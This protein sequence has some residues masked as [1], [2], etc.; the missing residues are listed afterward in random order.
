M[1][2]EQLNKKITRARYLCLIG[3]SLLTFSTIIASVFLAD[4]ILFGNFTNLGVRLY[5]L[6]IAIGLLLTLGSFIYLWGIGPREKNVH[7]NPDINYEFDIDYGVKF[8][9]GALIG[10]IGFFMVALDYFC[11]IGGIILLIGLQIGAYFTAFGWK[12]E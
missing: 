4:T 8:L 2:S 10:L 11:V 9:L 7:K 12:I 3:P 1:L 5:G 6:T